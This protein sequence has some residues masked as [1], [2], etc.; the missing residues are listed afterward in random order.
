MPQYP[1]SPGGAPYRSLSY[2]VVV[3]SPDG[4]SKRIDLESSLS[5]GRADDNDIPVPEN[6]V[7]RLHCVVNLVGDRPCLVDQ[8]STNGSYLNGTRVTHAWLA[9][10]DT[11]RVGRTTL[12]VEAV[13]VPG[14]PRSPVPTP[15]ASLPTPMSYSPA[16]PVPTPVEVQGTHLQLVYRLGTL[17]SSSTDE[18]SAAEAVID[19]VLEALP[20]ERVY[21]VAF[22]EGDTEPRTVA[23]AVR[24][25][26]RDVPGGP[27][28]TVLTMT[29]EQGEAVHSFDI[30]SDEP[31]SKVKSLTGAQ[32]RTVLSAPMRHGEEVIGVLYS[33][34]PDA[35][36]ASSLEASLTLYQAIADQA[37]LAIGRA[38][39]HRNLLTSNEQL[40]RQR[41]R[42]DE[43]S[44]RLDSRVREKS[45]L[46]EAQGAELAARLAELEHL[47]RARETMARGLVH[48]IRN[49]V[50]SVSSNLTFIKEECADGS[51]TSNASE[52][53]L[54]GTRQIVSLAEDVL[55]AS[56]IEAGAM[57]LLIQ[58]AVV[59][60]LLNSAVQRNS[61]RARDHGVRLRVGQEQP[62]AVV[63]ADVKLIGRVLDNLVG[64]AVR[65]AGG[66][67]ATRARAGTTASACT[68][69]ASPSRPM[70]A[71][72]GWRGPR[73][74]TG[75]SSPCHRG[76]PTTAWKPR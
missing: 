65:H 19:L 12:R 44:Q 36:E 43:L 75:S 22:D 7:S 62:G 16:M 27:S 58:T 11:V 30:V 13:D 64:N 37:A 42:L 28:R 25:G 17:L 1:G 18:K 76:A 8:S 72:S 32:A 9:H 67:P 55:T 60:R 54:E 59:D 73:E 26:T 15:R 49:L 48:D 41:D 39:A 14:T 66:T 3:T 33:D 5:V 71:A 70:G 34:A 29:L 45:A 6:A 61:G 57:E 68:S 2:R 56:R 31:L 53:A 23:S 50:S 4:A 47:Q 52:D 20:V 24:G 74:T 35:A 40:R 63:T 21:V 69:L 38:R 10:N 51:E 46:A